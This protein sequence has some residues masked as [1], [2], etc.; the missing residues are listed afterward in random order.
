MPLKVH[1]PRLPAA[2]TLDALRALVPDTVELTAGPATPL[3]SDCDILV[4]GTVKPEYLAAS[5]RLRAVIVPYAGVPVETQEL[6]RAY[7][8]ITL[9]NLHFNDIP[10]AEMALALMLA[11]SKYVAAL[12][13]RLR[14]GNWRLG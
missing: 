13:H 8:H 1:F 9:H 10:T 14:Q 7:P 11:A 6:L 3:P 2:D 12:D 5:P 4:T